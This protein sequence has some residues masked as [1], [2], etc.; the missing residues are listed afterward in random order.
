MSQ[1]MKK[2][3]PLQFKFRARYY[4]EDVSEELIQDI[5][6]KQFF[7][8]VKEVI[9]SDEVYCPPESAVLLASYAVQTKFGDFNK[10]VHKSGYLATERLLSQRLVNLSGYGDGGG[11]S[12]NIQIQVSVW[13]GLVESILLHVLYVW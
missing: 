6:Q 11:C 8:Q 5:T 3:V 13:R 10:E 9:L 12:L 1:D 4:P 7:L 2:E